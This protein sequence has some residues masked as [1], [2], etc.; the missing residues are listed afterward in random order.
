M[1]VIALV[2]LPGC[3]KTNLARALA[4]DWDWPLIDLD[5][6]IEAESGQPIAQLFAHGEAHFRQWEQRCLESVW[7]CERAVI[8]TGGGV[9]ENVANREVLKRLLTVFIDVPLAEAR[10]RVSKSDHR[11]L[12]RANPHAL[13]ELCARRRPLYLEVA[14]LR[15]AVDG[16]SKET[17]YARLKSALENSGLVTDQGGSQ[18]EKREVTR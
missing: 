15:V 5:D 18:I 9:V 16:A 7:Q 6:L 14:R 12:L 17:N 13:D 10:R 8:A 4:R 1:T 2:G 3:G 11:P